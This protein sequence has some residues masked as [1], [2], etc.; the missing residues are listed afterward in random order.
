MINDR[1][2]RREALKSVGLGGL[3]MAGISL[4]SLA[5]LTGRAG[6]Q[7]LGS[8]AS[9]QAGDADAIKVIHLYATP[10]GGSAVEVLTA[11]EARKPLPVMNVV[12]NSY[13]PNAVDWHNAPGKVFSINMA[14]NI[15]AETTDSPRHDIGPGD[16]VY[17]DDLTGKGHVTHLLTPVA[18][19]FLF[20]PDDFDIHEWVGQQG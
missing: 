9:P 19:L 15:Q 10:D 14:G 12:A 7:N 16:L 3:G 8:T 4:M 1:I 18:N 5:A 13:R 17:M 2:G 6:A 11:T 20:M